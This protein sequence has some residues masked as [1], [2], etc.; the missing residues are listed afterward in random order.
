MSARITPQGDKYVA[1]ARQ[2][3]IATSFLFLQLSASIKPEFPL[4]LDNE[5][6]V[7][8]L[9]LQFNYAFMGQILWLGNHHEI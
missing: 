9:D 2:I 4:I 6:Y 5:T 7:P 8:K 1:S 3:L